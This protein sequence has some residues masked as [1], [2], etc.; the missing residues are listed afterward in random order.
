MKEG[1]DALEQDNQFIALRRTSVV[2]VGIS[3][4]YCCPKENAVINISLGLIYPGSNK[5]L[6]CLTFMVWE[7][8][9]V[10]RSKTH[11]ASGHVFSEIQLRRFDEQLHLPCVGNFERSVCWNDTNN[12]EQQRCVE[13]VEAL[14]THK[15]RL[16]PL[17]DEFD[18]EIPLVTSLKN[19]NRVQDARK[20][21]C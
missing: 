11:F 12:R 1:Y 14:I 20:C 5:A 16:L 2:T 4:L 15:T 3:I 7:V 13:S 18:R 9:E 10:L 19:P 21:A 17:F 8:V 6:H